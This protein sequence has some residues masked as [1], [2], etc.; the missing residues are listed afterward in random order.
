MLSHPYPVCMC[1][2]MHACMCVYMH[3]SIVSLVDQKLDLLKPEVQT[4]M[5]H[6]IRVLATEFE[7]TVLA[8]SC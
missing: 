8:L 6:P 5:N 1:V 3:T 4:V 7:I 2:Y